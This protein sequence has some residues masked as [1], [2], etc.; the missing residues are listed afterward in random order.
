MK[1]K[2]EFMKLMTLD[3]I[4]DGIYREI[5]E[6]IGLENLIKIADLVGGAKIYIPKTE[7]L[8]RPARDMQIKSEFNGY[9]H[10]E[11]AQRYGLTETWVREICGEGKVKGQISL[12]DETQ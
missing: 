12:F 6:N 11:L 3:M 1:N 2:I 7:S 5:A 8:L 9:N 10:N 4:A